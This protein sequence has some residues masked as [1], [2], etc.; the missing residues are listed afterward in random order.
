[1]T[2]QQV[3]AARAAAA[4]TRQRARRRALVLAVSA[5]ALALLL[6]PV[7]LLATPEEQTGPP[8]NL[9]DGSIL[10]G[11]PNAPV[12]VVVYEDLLCPFCKMSHQ[13]NKAQLD[14]WTAQGRV[15]VLYRPIAFLDR[16]SKDQYSTRAL[17]AIGAVVDTA[18]KAFP[19]F[20]DALYAEQPAEGGPG[21]SDDRLVE[22]AVTA[23]APRDAVRKAVTDRRFAA[24]AA[25]VTQ[26]ANQD[27]V[28][29][30]P[31]VTVNGRPVQNPTEPKEVAA[32]VEAALQKS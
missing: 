23:G 24:W 26:K 3:R 10:V 31:T 5:A 19:A 12:T 11:Q 18:P 13:A 7:V 27:G 25:Q 16:A 21:L 14:E 6:V 29:S 9:V 2:P 20:H 32:A 22:L 15:K 30:T 28:A 4:R 17:N 8:R 1:M